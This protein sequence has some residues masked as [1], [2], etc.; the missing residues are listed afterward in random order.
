MVRVG[1]RPRPPPAGT[2]SCPAHLSTAHARACPYRTTNPGLSQVR[3]K[4]GQA[5]SKGTAT[6]SRSM[7]G[8]VRTIRRKPLPLT[9][10]E[11]T[12]LRPRRRRASS[13]AGSRRRRAAAD[14]YA[15]SRSQVPSGSGCSPAPRPAPQ[16]SWGRA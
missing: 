12:P 9:S 5:G 1:R 14:T 8:S 10:A 16:V 7:G 13:S 11:A 15:H 6:A 2:P 4:S 3:G